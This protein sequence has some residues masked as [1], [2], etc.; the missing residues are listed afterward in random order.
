MTGTGLIAM[1]IAEPGR[2]TPTICAVS[3]VVSEAARELVDA[4]LDAAGWVVQARAAL[5]L[6]AGQGRRRAQARAITD[7]QPSLGLS[8]VCLRRPPL[9]AV[10]GPHYRP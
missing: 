8:G 5:N 10:D 3:T 6:F 4:E 1:P 7:V 2:P 9:E